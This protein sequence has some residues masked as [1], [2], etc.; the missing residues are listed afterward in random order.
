MVELTRYIRILLLCFCSLS[1]A[2]AITQS[3]E[4]WSLEIS[5]HD[6]LLTYHPIR[7]LIS[8]TQ[9]R[10]IHVGNFSSFRNNY[11][12]SFHESVRFYAEQ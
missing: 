1:N 6:G 10:K 9:G 7:S 3:K 12:F 11:Q 2:R 8:F 4:E 5:V